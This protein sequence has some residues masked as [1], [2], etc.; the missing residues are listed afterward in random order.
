MR[1]GEGRRSSARV[2]VMVIPI[3]AQGA[4]GCPSVAD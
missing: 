1:V 3:L 4:G 2:L